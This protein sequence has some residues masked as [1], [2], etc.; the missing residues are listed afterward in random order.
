MQIK[1]KLKVMRALRGWS[2]EKM[3]EK[4]GYSAKGYAKIER[5]ETDIKVEQLEKIAETLGI[6][7][8]QFF[9]LNENNVF[10]IIELC[11]HSHITGS[12]AVLTE[13]QCVQELEKTQLLLQERD[14]EIAYLK[15]QIAQLQEINALLKTLTVQ[16][17]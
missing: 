15:Q 1:E 12:G 7:L 5:G 17:S 13:T 10:N 9:N 16:H 6:D 8:A 3:G 2:Q 14:K 11:H 4:L